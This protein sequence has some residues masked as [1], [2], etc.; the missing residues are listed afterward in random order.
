MALELCGQRYQV[1][2]NACAGS[3]TDWDTHYAEYSIADWEQADAHT[4]NYVSA[5]REKVQRDPMGG[6]M[7]VCG[8]VARALRLYALV[9]SR[10]PVKYAETVR[11][12]DA[13]AMWRAA[14]SDAAFLP[15]TVPD[16][17]EPLWHRVDC[18]RRAGLHNTETT[19][20]QY[21]TSVVCWY[22]K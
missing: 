15:H 16:A 8:R 11:C 4:Y 7:T 13:T 5:G 19:T 22:S 14:L 6:A 20:K 1:C 21:T 9:H 12:A 10:R 17:Q 3:I 18:G 2:A